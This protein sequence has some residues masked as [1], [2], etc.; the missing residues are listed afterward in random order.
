MERVV[1]FVWVVGSLVKLFPDAVPPESPA[2]AIELS[3]ARNEYES[4]QIAV[5]PTNAIERL[6]VRVSDL[7]QAE[8]QGAIP[9]AHVRCRFVGCVPIEHNTYYTPDEELICKAPAEVPDVLL[10][11]D[12]I[13]LAA[14]RTQS[15]WVS[16]YVPMDT[17]AGPYT[18][19]V[20]VDA[21]GQVIS[22]PIT[23]HVHD[24]AVPEERHLYVTNWF[25][26]GNVCA[27]VGAERGSD[28]H[29]RMLGVY[30]ANMGTH[31][32]NVF[33]VPWR[34]I[35]VTR[36]ADG[37]LSFDYAKFDRY[38]ETFLSAGVDGRIELHATA[39]RGEGGWSSPDVIP[40]TIQAKD[41]ASGES[42][43]LPPEQG[44]G[45]LLAD[46]ERHLEERGW[47][48][49]AMIH[50]SDEPHLGNIDGWRKASA[51][52]HQYAPR[53]KRIE[54][55]ETRNFHD[56]L[57]VWV[58]KLSHLRNWYP[59][60]DDAR[61]RGNEMWYYICCHPTGLYPNRFLDYSLAKVR[62][63][64]W[65]NYRY[66]LPGYL[67][68]G[69]NFW[70]GDP[71]A[72]PDK[73]LPP[74]D[75]NIVYPGPADNPYSLL[76]SIRWEVQRD[77]IEDF[78]YLWLLEHCHAQVRERLGDPA[79]DL[80]ASARSRELCGKLVRTFTDYE[81]DPAGIA[82]VRDQL[83]REIESALEPPLLLWQSAPPMDQYVA[84]GP[85]AVEI[86]GVTEPGARVSVNG[87]NVTLSQDGS[88][89]GWVFKW[90][91]AFDATV[92]VETDQGT[93]EQTRH[94]ESR[95]KG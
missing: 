73:G 87:R 22:V 63:L 50:I 13:A 27:P 83:T 86:H 4:A 15:I 78:E 9:A 64:H 5:R 54:A 39:H 3:C 8:G 26:D 33:W 91:A 44:L 29:Y 43:S 85:T 66:D 53:I 31:R 55:I 41:A 40:V 68:W 32:Q 58:P 46:L 36:D 62:L 90:D 16:V 74:G 51:F 71:F 76:D 35:A 11:D 17:Q 7:S 23:V 94:F 92:K 61:K 65:I 25:S 34:L 28:E 95:S 79:K 14:D 89:K 49:R 82:S 20:E 84:A 93:K 80:D 88:F 77:S 12:T 38:I 70:K 57:E 24:F 72:A 81:K 60:F 48:E 2:T 30:A 6:T 19:A 42:V 52:V 75:R 59:W 37:A 67:H 10:A 47:L 21:D 18:G 1:T 56:A 69:F 45:P